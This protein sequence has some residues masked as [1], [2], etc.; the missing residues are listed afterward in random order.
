MTQTDKEKLAAEHPDAWIPVSAGEI[1]EGEVTDFNIA[2]SDVSQSMYPILTVVTDN[3]LEVK[4]HAFHTALHNEIYTKQPIPGE[5]V[6][7]VYH[8]QGEAKVKGQSPPE[9]YRLRVHNR[10]PE[11]YGRMYAQLRPKGREFFTPP[12]NMGIP[13]ALGLPTGDGQ[14]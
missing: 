11:A 2:Y 8:G 6:T 4:V 10:S 3:G 12:P 5:R 14:S 13:A 1:L 7:V 9:I